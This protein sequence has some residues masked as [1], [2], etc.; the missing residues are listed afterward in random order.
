MCVCCSMQPYMYG[1]SEGE[2][3]GIQIHKT[4]LR[5][6]KKNAEKNNAHK[7]GEVKM[8]PSKET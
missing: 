6:N 7:R 5:Q 4:R 1:Q 3:L 8:E 2:R